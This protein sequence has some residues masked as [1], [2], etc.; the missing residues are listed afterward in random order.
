MQ[1]CGCVTSGVKCGPVSTLLQENSYSI[2][3][4]EGS[5]R[6][7][8]LASYKAE[9]RSRVIAVG[10]AEVILNEVCMVMVERL[11]RADGANVSAT[12]GRALLE[13]R[14]VAV[15]RYDGRR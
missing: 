9:V 2:H 11:G 12:K 5:A 4:V 1:S 8:E 10:K 3:A 6:K 13:V 7:A 15:G 14:G